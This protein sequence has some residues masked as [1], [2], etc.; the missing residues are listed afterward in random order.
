MAATLTAFPDKLTHPGTWWSGASEPHPPYL[1]SNAGKLSLLLKEKLESRTD[2][3]HA[4]VLLL[5]TLLK[6]L[7]SS[8]F[9]LH[10]A[11]LRVSI[12]NMCASFYLFVYFIFSSHLGGSVT[13][14]IRT[15][16]KKVPLKV[17]VPS[18]DNPNVQWFAF[19]H[20]WNVLSNFHRSNMWR[21]LQNLDFIFFFHHFRLRL[22]T[23]KPPSWV[24]CV[25]NIAGNTV[26]VSISSIS[27][28]FNAL[29]TCT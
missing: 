24:Y 1:G 20:L 16:E 15:K 14:G 29:T 25:P 5:V 6:S 8:C 27:P 13:R 26:Y 7:F 22:W 11:I 28:K 18:E 4:S 3:A 10:V 19:H 2:A 12:S 9:V 23:D 17:S 21:V